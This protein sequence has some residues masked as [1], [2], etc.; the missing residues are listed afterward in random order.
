MPCPNSARSVA[1][2]PAA[3]V[4]AALVVPAADAPAALPALEVVGRLVHPPIA[5]ASGLAESRRRPGVCWTLTDSG[6]PARLFAVRPD[7]TLLADVEVKGAVNLD[8]ESLAASGEGEDA[9]LYVCDVGN[10]LGLPVRWVYVLK[11]PDLPEPADGP[12]GPDGKPLSVPVERVIA[13]RF[14]E[15]EPPAD[16]EGVVARD[17][18][19][20][21]FRK[22]TGR[23]AAGSGR[24]GSLTT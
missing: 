6:G 16:V 2:M 24:T 14:P 15:G 23:S 18:E 9:R 12:G 22:T 11:E 4:L 13:Y 20:I 5:E 19:L 1:L 3:A 17:G 21:L 10:N 7:G 8:W